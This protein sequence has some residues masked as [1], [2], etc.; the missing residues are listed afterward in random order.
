MRVRLLMGYK[1]GVPLNEQGKLTWDDDNK[2]KLPDNLEVTSGGIDL[3]SDEEKYSKSFNRLD[4]IIDKMSYWNPTNPYSGFNNDVTEYIKILESLKVLKPYKHPLY[5]FYSLQSVYE[6]KFQ[7]SSLVNHTCSKDRIE[8][9][10]PAT[11]IFDTIYLDWLISLNSNGGYYKSNCL[12]PSDPLFN[13]TKPL[14]SISSGVEKVEAYVNPKDSIEDAKNEFNLVMSKIPS[15]YN[16]LPIF[17]YFETNPFSSSEEN[18]QFRKWF[19]TRFPKTASLIKLDSS[20]KAK[21]NKYTSNLK[22][23]VNQIID[24][25]R[26]SIFAFYVY[27]NLAKKDKKKYLEWWDYFSPKMMQTGEIMNKINE[28]KKLFIEKNDL[29]KTPE[30]LNQRLEMLWNFGN[31]A[32]RYGITTNIYPS[33]DWSVDVQWDWSAMQSKVYLQYKPTSEKC[34]FRIQVNYT[35]QVNT[36]NFVSQSFGMESEEKDEK[37]VAQ[38]DF[39][40]NGNIIE[41]FAN[42]KKVTGTYWKEGDY[43]KVLF[44]GYPKSYD[45]S[46]SGLNYMLTEELDLIPN[47]EKNKNKAAEL[48]D[49]SQEQS[50]IRKQAI[51]MGSNV[52]IEGDLSLNPCYPAFQKKLDELKGQGKDIDKKEVRVEAW[53]EFVKCVDSG[54]TGD[55]YNKNEQAESESTTLETLLKNRFVIKNWTSESSISKDSHGAYGES[56][57]REAWDENG[58]KG[59]DF[60]INVSKGKQYTQSENPKIIGRVY[61]DNKTGKYFIPV[62]VIPTGGEGS[63]WVY[64]FYDAHPIISQIIPSIL[65][66]VFTGSIAAPAATRVILFAALESGINIATAYLDYATGNI[67]DDY[68][69]VYVDII[70]AVLPLVIA[71]PGVQSILHGKFNAYSV[72]ALG[73]KIA[74]NIKLGDNEQVIEYFIKNMLTDEERQVLAYICKYEKGSLFREWAKQSKFGESLEKLKKLYGDPPK[75]PKNIFDDLSK[76][77]SKTVENIPVKKTYGNVKELSI[78]LSPTVLMAKDLGLLFKMA[79]CYI[80]DWKNSLD[81]F[82]KEMTEE[83]KQK[84]LSIINQIGEDEFKKLIA[85]KKYDSLYD[86]IIDIYGEG[87]YGKTND[88]GEAV[89]P[90]GSII[91]DVEKDKIDKLIENVKATDLKFCKEKSYPGLQYDDTFL[92]THE[93]GWCS[94]DGMYHCKSEVTTTTTTIEP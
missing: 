18:S 8:N 36:S 66:S 10:T 79:Y 90:N 52:Q 59:K 14:Q 84:T 93:C 94:N 82:Q 67:G 26:E 4:D 37:Y 43:I 24:Y 76:K 80:G 22:M 56:E 13:F 12:R 77:V 70:F 83:E 51:A 39:K 58:Q 47:D 41:I 91:D 63:P 78:Y 85:D 73:K 42:G 31:D 61:Y 3:Y 11:L 54:L 6:N 64:K 17:N 92:E 19:N 86:K 65:A 15:D 89:L 57:V 44:P 88:K 71:T 53:T 2:S 40:A 9:L 62:E 30:S 5:S 68:L 72:D 35:K 60:L 16:S 32:E 25:G 34:G 49:K 87:A 1:V 74:S 21:Q 50:D 23:A 20:D 45:L 81:C 75:L 38:I 69:Y 46:I 7:N 27:D 33:N 29:S 48:Y 28:Q 55:E